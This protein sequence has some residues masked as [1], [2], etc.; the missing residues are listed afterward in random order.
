MSKKHEL[1]EGAGLMGEEVTELTACGNV[2]LTSLFQ[3]QAGCTDK[4]IKRA[5][6][7]T[8]GRGCCACQRA[9][10]ARQAAIPHTTPWPCPGPGEDGS[11]DLLR[12]SRLWSPMSN[13]GAP[14]P[15]GITL[16]FQMALGVKVSLI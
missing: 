2:L 7:H 11:R 3:A 15:P 9:P 10:G 16:H 5:A 14:V 13:T 1:G 12:G 8:A 4:T 6:A